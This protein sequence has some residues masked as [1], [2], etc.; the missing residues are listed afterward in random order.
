MGRFGQG[1]GAGDGL[2]GRDDLGALLRVLENVERLT[3]LLRCDLRGWRG[4]CV[5]GRLC[6]GGDAGREREQE[7]EDQQ[8]RHRQAPDTIARGRSTKWQGCGWFQGLGRV[9]PRAICVG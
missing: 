1:L 6:A 8:A 3:G 5:G 9:G 7:G 2:Q 4:G